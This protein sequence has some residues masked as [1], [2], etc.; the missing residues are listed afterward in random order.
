[1]SGSILCLRRFAILFTIWGA[2]WTLLFCAQGPASAHGVRS[3]KRGQ[4]IS[5]IPLRTLTREEVNAQA[6]A[7]GLPPM[8]QY[9]LRIVKISY[10]TPDVNGHLV[11]ASGAL[12]LPVGTSGPLP[13]LSYQHGTQVTRTSTSSTFNG[14]IAFV[15][16]V[17]AASGY[18]VISADYLGLGDAP[19]PHPYLHADSEATACTDML[20]AARDA[21]S[22]LNVAF[23]S[24]LFLTGYSQGGHVTMALHRALERDAKRE[25]TV[26]ASAP[27]DGP[28]DLSGSVLPAVL[29]HPVEHSGFEVAYLL[30]AYQS[31]YKIYDAHNAAFAP[32][33]DKTLPPLFDSHH[34]FEEISATVPMDPKHYLK[35][36]FVHDV[37]TN[38]NNP[39]FKAL[40]RNNVYDWKPVAP[41]KL[42]HAKG[43]GEVTY[44]NAEVAYAAMKKHG[45]NVTLVNTG[46]TLD[47]ATGYAP[48]IFAAKAWFDSLR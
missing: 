5:V 28:Y 22:G 20:R 3:E 34:T 8:A 2:A 21:A 7:D 19:G 18:A 6:Q 41:V 31:L 1:M 24:K 17:F 46:D 29:D 15:A 45:A 9:G 39:T 48:A 44:Q 26:T 47:H 23:G 37:R 33:Y 27:L 30:T 14:E 25:F 32:P 40:K 42:I 11:T 36:D 16:L 38:P 10:K 35:P 13:L 4:V 43:D 12:V